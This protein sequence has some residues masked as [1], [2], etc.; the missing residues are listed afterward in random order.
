MFREDRGEFLIVGH[1][2]QIAGGKERREVESKRKM[3]R[4]AW[5]LEWV[6]EEASWASTN[7]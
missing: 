3:C 6:G 7:N 2:F 4:I 5:E 1:E